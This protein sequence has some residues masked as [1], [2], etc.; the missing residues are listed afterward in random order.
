MIINGS[1]KFLLD[2]LIQF[3][4]END[5]FSCGKRTLIGLLSWLIN[6]II[7]IFLLSDWH[8]DWLFLGLRFDGFD[9]FP[10]KQDEWT[11]EQKL[12]Y[13][14]I[15]EDIQPEEIK[16][17]GNYAVTITWPN[18]F[19]QVSRIAFGLIIGKIKSI[20]LMVREG[21][22]FFFLFLSWVIYGII[23]KEKN[24]VREE[25]KPFSQRPS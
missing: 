14:D 3:I 13:G 9:F 25:D 7:R 8:Y 4:K 21:V 10:P 2:H 6:V 20:V 15:P 16:P 18:G 12:Q 1:Q 23:K 11:G 17:M 22:V 5:I 19:N 24:K